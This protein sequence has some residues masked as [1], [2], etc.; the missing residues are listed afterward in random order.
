MLTVLALPT[1]RKTKQKIN[2][3]AIV[4]NDAFCAIGCTELK[5]MEYQG[6]VFSQLKL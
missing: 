1:L 5:C 6:T 4:D 2:C 3:L